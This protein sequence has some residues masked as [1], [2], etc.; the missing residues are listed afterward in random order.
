[1]AG[2]EYRV[3]ENTGNPA[4]PSIEDVIDLALARAAEPRPPD[5]PEEYFDRYVHDAV[6][7]AS[8][9]AVEQSI[10]LSLT[11]GLTHRMAGREAFGHDDYLHGINVGVAATAY[12]RELHDDSPTT[13]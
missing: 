10:R 3:R 13:A 11:E 6:E 8:E 5:H 4:H 7:H 9:A 1:M 12:L 2:E